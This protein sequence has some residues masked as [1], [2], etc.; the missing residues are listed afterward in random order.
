V[1]RLLIA[2]LIAV[3]VIFGLWSIVFTDRMLIY[4]IEKSLTDGDLHVEVTDLKKGLFFDF[5]SAHMTLKKSDRALIS[6]DDV[7][8]RINPLKLLSGKPP[9]DFRG[10]V[11]GGRIDGEAGFLKRSSANIRVD[12]ANIEEIPFFALSGLE[13]NGTLSGE[14]RL[15][16]GTGDIKFVVKDAHL[17]NGSFGGV[18]VPLDVFRDAKGAMS[19]EGPTVKIVSFSLEGEGIYAR[20]KGNIVGKRL[21]VT[22]ELMPER[23][24]KEALIFSALENYRVSPGYFVIPIT[25][26]LSF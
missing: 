7:T 4:G 20:I 21:D 14:F 15:A 23:S 1:I 5:K 24:F 6:I 10:N 13:G 26:T 18:S 3:A 9:L 8:G 12:K 2:C 16:K 17:K 19:I 25:K 22:L 11:G